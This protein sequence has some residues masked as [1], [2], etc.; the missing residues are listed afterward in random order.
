LAI[1][2][3]QIAEKHGFSRAAVEAITRALKQGNGNQAQFNHP[4]LG[5]MGQ[6]QP[7]MI[8]IGDAFN[9]TLKVRVDALCT[10]LAGLISQEP[11]HPIHT[12][13]QNRWWPQDFGEP[14]MVGSQN[15]ARYAYFR[16]KNRLVIQQNRKNRIYDVGQHVL[17]GSSQQQQQAH[18]LL[19]FHT[20]SGQIVTEADFEPVNS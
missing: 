16:L 10:D 11:T 19:I 12:S 6:W 1:N 17:V 5:G 4:E 9:H 8:M 18:G 15:E 3:D 14:T 7:N 2:Y 20:Q 13:Q